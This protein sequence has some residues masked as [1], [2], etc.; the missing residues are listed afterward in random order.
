ML[1][2]GKIS[3]PVTI[4][5]T[6][7][8]SDW[9][10]RL[11]PLGSKPE[12]ASTPRKEPNATAGTP[13]TPAAPTKSVAPSQNAAAANGSNSSGRVRGAQAS[14]GRPGFQRL[15][16]NATGDAAALPGESTGSENDL[17]SANLNQNANEAMVVNGSVSNGV[18]APQQ[19]DWMMYGGGQGGPGGPVGPG[20]P[21]FGGA[22]GPGSISVGGPGGPEVPEVPAAVAPE[23]LADDSQAAAVV[24]LAVGRV[25][26]ADLAQP[27]RTAAPRLEMRD[28]AAG[29]TTATSRLF[30]T[31]Q[32]WMPNRIRS[33]VRRRPNWLTHISA[34]TARSVVR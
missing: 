14:V 9:D 12:S 32:R 25:A 15:D 3:R 2:F 16:V 29:S 19:N 23:G 28:G 7:A 21:P 17:T 8:N 6:G 24:F 33:P 5:P 34:P 20:G 13:S 31:T 18:N 1:G 30:W 11:L 27:E 4:A 10:L 22:G 26:A